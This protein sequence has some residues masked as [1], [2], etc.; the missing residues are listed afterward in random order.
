MPRKR[1]TSRIQRVLDDRVPCGAAHARHHHVGRDDRR[2][3]PDRHA[4]RDRPVGAGRDDDAEALELEHHVGDQRHHPDERDQSAEQG[5]VVPVAEIV[6]LGNQMVG[7]CVTP[8]RRQQPVG[9]DVGEAAVAEDVIG[10]AA[11]AVGPAAAAE[12]G[13]GRIDLAGQ[14]QEDEDRPE[15]APGHG[16]LLEVHVLAVGGAQAEP[17][18]KRGEGEDDQERRVHSPPPL[19]GVAAVG[20]IEGVNHRHDDRGEHHPH[21]QPREQKRHAQHQRLRPD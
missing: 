8:D 20:G 12:E 13:E 3:D 21:H 6:R 18:R 2:A 10:R 17:Q 7:P 4:G 9:Q 15:A 1:T 19:V 14:Q 5:A 11:L 16:P